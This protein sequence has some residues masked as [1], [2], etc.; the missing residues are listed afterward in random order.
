[1]NAKNRLIDKLLK[2]AKK[3]KILTYPVLALVAVIS[4]FNYFFSW[5]TGAGKRVVAVVMV[6]VMLVSQ[7]Y[8]LTSSASALVDTDET[9]Q[10][11]QELQE[12]SDDGLVD[13][14]ET[15]GEDLVQSDTPTEV[16][17]ED[18]AGDLDDTSDDTV[19]ESDSNETVTTEANTDDTPNTEDVSS[20]EDTA[21]TDDTTQSGETE[22]TEEVPAYA[23]DVQEPEKTTA[24]EETATVVFVAVKSDS[25]PEVFRCTATKN[26]SG[27]TYKITSASWEADA[28]RNLA[29]SYN[30]GNYLTYAGWYTSTDYSVKVDSTVASNLSL[31]E[32]GIIWL[33]AKEIISNYK[34]SIGSAGTVSPFTVSGATADANENGI[35]AVPASPSGNSYTGSFTIV[36]PQRAGYELSGIDRELSGAGVSG[37]VNGEDLNVTLSGG[38]YT[39]NV[40]LAWTA[41]DYDIQYQAADSVVTQTV[42]YDGQE[43]SDL[44]LSENS[45][46]VAEKEG[47]VFAGWE[48]NG[49]AIRI[50]KDRAGVDFVSSYSAL[51]SYAY[52]CAKAGS[53]ALLT[54]Y[55]DYAG[56][57]L[58]QDM[59]T[60]EYRSTQNEPKVITAVY[61]DNGL[62]SDTFTY[63]LGTITDGSGQAV[64]PA[65]Y[66]INV[67]KGDG[68]A[69]T[70]GIRDTG[71]T[72]VITLNVEVLI[73]DSRVQDP[74][75]STSKDTLTIK[76]TPCQLTLDTSSVPALT[77]VYDGTDECDFSGAIETNIDGVTVRIASSQ[78]DNANVGER[79]VILTPATDWLD[80][81]GATDSVDNYSIQSNANGNFVVSGTIKQREVNVRTYAVLGDRDYIRAGEANPV[82]KAE[83]IASDEEDEGLLEKDKNSLSTLITLTADPER[84]DSTMTTSR[85]VT[86]RVVPVDTADSNYKFN[87]NYND[88]G[89]FKV[90][91][92][93]ADT[94]FE[95]IGKTDSGWFGTGSKIVPKEDSGYNQIRLEGGEADSQIL[96]TEELA[97][98]EKVVFQLY[99][100]GTQAYTAF[101]TFPVKVDLTNPEYI[102][103]EV[104]ENGLDTG[105]GLYFPAAGGQVSLGHYYNKS[106]TFRVSYKDTASGASKLVYSLSGNLTDVT[107]SAGQ[108]VSFVSKIDGIST[109][110]FTI[111][112]RDLIDQKGGIQFYAIDAANN[113]SDLMNLVS[114]GDEWIVEKTA[115]NIEV[116]IKAGGTSSTDGITI[117][118]EDQETYFGN[119][120]AYLSAQDATSP[121]TSITWIINGEEHVQ[122]LDN[123]PMQV[124]TVLPI[125]AT[126]FTPLDGGV[127]TVSAYVTDKAGNKS[128]TTDEVTF[129]I[130]D[131]KPVVNIDDG[132]DDYQQEVKLTF[133]AYDELSGIKYINVKDLQSDTM[134]QHVVEKVEQN[135]AGF[136]TSYCYV[137]TTKQGS[138]TIEVSDNAGNVYTETIELKNVS[139]EV[140]ACPTVTF[141][142]EVNENGWITADEAKASIT[143]VK[144]TEE[145]KM[146]VDTK[147]QIWKDG[148]TSMHVTT[149]DSDVD[150]EEI[151]LPNGIYQLRVWSES[152]T[153]VKCDGSEENGHIYDIQVDSVEPVIEYT[154]AKGADNSLVVN[155]TVKDDISGVNSEKIQVYNG[156]R[157]IDAQIT[158]M[159][160]GSGY[161]GTFNITEVGS[162]TI[163][164]EDIAGNVATAPAF[165]PMSMKVNAVKNI[166]ATAAT[167]GARVIK[168]TYDIQSATIAYRKFD[169]ATYTEADALPVLDE[170]TGNVAV[171]ALLNN[172]EKGTNYVYKVTA[173]SD[174]GEVLEYVGYF[175]T[176]ADGESGIT[177]SGSAR[178]ADGRDGY[179]TVGLFAGQSCIRAVEVDTSVDNTFTFKDVPDG[180]YSVVATDGVYSK[181]AR[182]L[183][184]SGRIIYPET[185]TL[186]LVL[187]GKNTAVE[188]TTAETPYVTADNMDSLFDDE[189]NYTDED[190]AIIENGGTI[191][192]RLYATLMK[193]SDVSAEEIAAMYSAA[194]H[195]NKLVGAYL[196]FTLYKI[197]TDA[198]GN[199]TKKRVT[200]LG[201]GA[202]ISVTIPLGD[203]AN[204]S[205]LEVVRTHDTG[206]TYFGTYLVDQDNNPSTYT[207]TTTL[208]STYAILYDPEKKPASTEEIKDGKIDP[209]DDGNILLPF[210]TKDKEP[211]T[212]APKDNNKDN[213]NN[214]KDDK[215]DNEK[216]TESNS[217]VETLK[218]SGSAE[219][220]DATPIALVFGMMLVAIGGFFVLRKKVKD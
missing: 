133:D 201:G 76:V 3:H 64:D 78:F 164:A 124:N 34:V 62:G 105:S 29:T 44:I 7:S 107:D 205:G 213:E 189:T 172:L 116:I 177:V 145:D 97:A 127:F 173:L 37:T 33:Y 139:S 192:F 13:D 179:I 9:V 49:G 99:D 84:D 140:P 122:T 198:D 41:E 146:L 45:V 6:L 35:Y 93:S 156:S 132:Y 58:L 67:S 118:G 188:L 77:K 162:Y 196:D 138:Y 14:G 143:N 106:I 134:I 178:Y 25:K 142:P 94:L 160:D 131:V 180:T 171:S 183:I 120:K 195:K 204:K 53:P 111:P 10:E 121:I 151:T 92:E 22:N 80:F 109:F 61:K 114:A 190:R 100:S 194:S 36:Q 181:N 102:G 170:T 214:K 21:Y 218:S 185:A 15:E 125:N 103:C 168:G 4:V 211:D 210:D 167:V 60:Y 207:V 46:D 161:T 30:D 175:R 51:Q 59:I 197:I 187:S 165:T 12:Q 108:E 55:Y 47:Y 32:P 57:E 153:G 203:L 220:G 40:Q 18:P 85:D 137:T 39:Q 158:E 42:T 119:V 87:F 23:E 174:G 1:M 69:I 152:L 19:A 182:V 52:G 112:V 126:S 104:V 202:N 128:L 136:K 200:E 176:L 68:K 11:Q 101:T 184:H 117:T 5:S 123:E 16:T 159:E 113:K 166:S 157:L 71:L 191:E 98:D 79:S 63:D 28:N 56:V 66:G 186:D 88:L 24:A 206:D 115:P 208:F 148:E 17:T 72:G 144:M 27:D 8:F 20:T 54:P 154:L 89:T 193:V 130:D 110:T 73:T 141:D 48:T 90:R 95:A 86:Y 169:A 65:N 38:D 219:T 135:E 43:S 83:E 216:S 163:M 2:V 81:G 75:E 199:V 70:V 31:S 91:L 82:F 217:S 215:K 26:E 147:Y 150:V 209:S 212:D 50:P 129:K 149:L 96:L 155:F 74:D